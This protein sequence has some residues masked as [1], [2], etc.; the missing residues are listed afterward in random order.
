MKVEVPKRKR[1]FCIIDKATGR[2]TG[3]Y[4]RAC[5]DE[6]DFSSPE[7]ARSANCHG[8]FEDRERY[9]IAEYEVIYRLVNPEVAP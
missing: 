8:M 2:R 5:H 3:S 7:S 6:Y 1:V 9:D 4:S